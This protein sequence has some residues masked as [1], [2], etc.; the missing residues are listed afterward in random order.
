MAAT[1][2]HW[3][4]ST[5]SSR[6]TRTTTRCTSSAAPSARPSAITS[7]PA[8]IGRR[9]ARCCPKTRRRST[10]GPGLHATGPID[11]R[12]PERAVA[13][14]RRAVALAPGQ[15]L[16]LNTLGVA[17]YR[18]GQY[19]EAISVLERSLAAGKGEFDAFDLFFL[20]MAHQK[21][22][23]ASQARACFYRAV[24]WW[25][26]HKNL[27]AQ[28]VPELTGFRAEAEEVLAVP[29]LNCLPTCSRRVAVPEPS[30]RLPGRD[31]GGPRRVWAGGRHEPVPDG[32]TCQGDRDAA[33][34][35][36]EDETKTP[37]ELVSG[38]RSILVHV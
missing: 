36:D 28:Y 38:S 24:R 32:V 15:Q 20:A 9:L 23:H 18:A 11:Q 1:A 10:I 33:G 37:G 30:R 26:E 27:P 14:A 29:A 5:S 19:A 12:D 34:H 21:L 16:T 35:I 4:T 17:L 2:R 13:L 31:L 8:P 22:G 6:N 3:P 25:G 7:K